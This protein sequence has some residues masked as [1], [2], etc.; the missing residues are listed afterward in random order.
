MSEPEEY[1]QVLK[2]QIADKDEQ[3][4]QCT[5]A[6]IAAKSVIEEYVTLL[7]EHGL[8]DK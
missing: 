7:K 4:R 2:E 8:D 5:Q 1:I 6:L 3:I